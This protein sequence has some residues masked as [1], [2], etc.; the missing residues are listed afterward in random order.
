[1]SQLIRQLALILAAALLPAA[2]SAALQ[3]RWRSETPLQPGEIR[4]STARLWSHHQ[5][6]W[7]DIRPPARFEAAHIPGAFNCPPEQWTTGS[8]EVLARWS[9]EKAVVI[10]GDDDQETQ[11]HAMSQRMR[12][13]LGFETTYV[14]KGGWQAWRR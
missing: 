14:L 13:Q 7:V 4:P 10:Y 6:L 1:M 8:Q 2:A 3:L 11:A 12:E 5:V 9:A